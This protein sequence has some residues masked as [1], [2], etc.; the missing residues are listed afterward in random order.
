MFFEMKVMVGILSV[1]ILFMGYF[2]L[3]VGW[4]KLVIEVWIVCL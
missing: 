2:G 1:L 4:I 3:V